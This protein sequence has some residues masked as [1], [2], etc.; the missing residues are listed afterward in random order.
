MA[1]RLG[2]RR[3]IV[4]I[5][6]TGRYGSVQ[7][8]HL[9]ECDHVEVRKRASRAPEIACGSCVAGEPMPAPL[10]SLEPTESWDSLL[11]SVEHAGAVAQAAIATRLGVDA[12]AVN[13][14]MAAGPEGMKIA[15]ATVY[16]SADEVMRLARQ[17]NK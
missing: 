1:R 3:R 2:P 17:R 15:G 13:V 11:A 10:G 16:L 8:L 9:L 7:Y 4:Q 12:D 5:S 14:Q 6:R